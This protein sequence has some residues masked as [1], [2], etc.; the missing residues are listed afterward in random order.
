MADV[1]CGHSYTMGYP[2]WMAWKGGWGIKI[3]LDHLANIAQPGHL[4]LARFPRILQVEEQEG[5]EEFPGQGRRK[6]F[7]PL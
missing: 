2:V 5:W 4:S 6:E 1:C 7:K 3:L